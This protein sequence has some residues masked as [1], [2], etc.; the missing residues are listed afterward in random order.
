MRAQLKTTQIKSVNS[1]SGMSRTETF[2]EISTT[3]MTSIVCTP[4]RALEVLE[5]IDGMFEIRETVWQQ[6]SAHVSHI[7]LKPYEMLALRDAL[8]KLQIMDGEQKEA[9]R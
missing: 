1:P 4:Y 8:N 5:S 9:R 3:K 6:Q 7:W 2:T